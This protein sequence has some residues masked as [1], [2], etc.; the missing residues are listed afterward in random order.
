MKVIYVVDGY[1]SESGEV[2]LHLYAKR[3]KAERKL[4]RIGK[5]FPH[6]WVGISKLRVK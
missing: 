4:A 5:K 1:D 2:I 6:A 3:K